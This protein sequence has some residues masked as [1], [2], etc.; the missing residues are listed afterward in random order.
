MAKW[1]DTT[2]AIPPLRWS[3]SRT[4]FDHNQQQ[5]YFNSH[6]IPKK[7]FWTMVL[8]VVAWSL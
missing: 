8:K 6:L 1:L 5:E 2:A 3:D 4:L 7:Y